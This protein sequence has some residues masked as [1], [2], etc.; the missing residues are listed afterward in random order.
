[1]YLGLNIY[2]PIPTI[3]YLLSYNIYAE[4]CFY[5]DL[6][7]AEGVR[8]KTNDLIR[9]RTLSLGLVPLIKSKRCF[10]MLE[11]FKRSSSVRAFIMPTF[12]SLIIFQL[13]NEKN[14][15]QIQPGRDGRTV[16]SCCV[17]CSL[18]GHL[19]RIRIYGT[20]FFRL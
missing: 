4:L 6:H 9:V 18:T 19:G 16:G 10:G 3:H 7:L 20:E 15:V 2:I 14:T 8:R 13:G 11:P 12:C 17:S 5:W 1:M